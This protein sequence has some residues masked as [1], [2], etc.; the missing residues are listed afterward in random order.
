MAARDLSVGNF[1]VPLELVE[2]MERGRW[3]PPAERVLRE[4]FGDDPDDAHFYDFTSMVRQN[5][6]FHAMA[7]ADYTT[8]VGADDTDIDPGWCVVIGDLGADMPIALDYRSDQGDPRVIYLGLGGWREVAPS[9]G[10]LAQLL[11]L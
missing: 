5:E 4:V 1:T 10:V 2:I 9:F 3:L 7:P 6:L 11:Q 8:L